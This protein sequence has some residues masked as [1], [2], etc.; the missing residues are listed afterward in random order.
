[1][2]CRRQQNSYGSDRNQKKML[3]EAVNLSGL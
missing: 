2:F 3:K 1:M